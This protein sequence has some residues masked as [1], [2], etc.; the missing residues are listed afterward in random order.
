MFRKA[1][2]FLWSSFSGLIILCIVIFLLMGTVMNKKSNE[3]INEIGTLYM[4]EMAKQVQQKFD[5]VIDL[6]ILEVNGI[7][8]GNPP[9]DFY[10]GAEMIY[11]LSRSARVRN[12]VYLGLYTT[13]GECETIYG[14]PVE[15]YDEETFTKVLNDN[16]LRVF[17][18]YNQD[19]EKMLLLIIAAEY[20]MKN[21]KTSTAMVAGLPMEYLDNVLALSDDDAIVYSHIIRRDGTF[22][23]RTRDMDYFTRIGEMFTEVDGKTAEEYARE[24]QSA[25]NSDQDYSATIRADG[26]Y[27]HVLCTHLPDS[28]WYLVTVMPFGVLDETVNDLSNQHQYI[29]LGSC[30]IIL[31]AVLIIFALY[32]RMTRGQLRELE[33]AEQEA[34]RA[35]RAKS[36]FL[37]NMSHD[38]RT[39][40]NGI[41]GMT[42]IAMTNIQDTARVQDCLQKITLS[43]KHLLGLINDVLDMSKIESGKLSLNMD[44]LS[45]R[46][47][48]DSIVNIVQPQIKAKNQHFDIFISKIQTEDVYCDSVRLNQVL[49]NLLSNAIKF[50]PEGGTIN[51]Y[52]AQ[53][54]S[55]AGD[56]YVRC[57]FRV[58][59]TGIGMS[60]EF[61]QNIFETFTREKNEQVNKTEGTGLG[62]AITK[63][64]VDAMKGEIKVTS[65]PGKG[66]EFH[67]T[68]DLEKVAAKEEE[69]ILPPW[70][71][72]VVDNNK[73]LC[74]S[75]VDVLGE[76]GISA[77]WAL[78]GRTAVDMAEKHHGV[79]DDYQLVL[80]DWKM[81]DMDGLETTRELRK[82]LGE[83]V[84]I[85]IISAYDWSDI[86]KE[87][88]EAGAQGFISKPL[89]KSN[90]FMGLSR[91]V[92]EE[93]GVPE[94]KEEHIRDFAGKRI[95]LAEDNDLNWEIANEILTCAGF[96]LDR[97]EN[98]KIC[99]EKFEQSEPGTYDLILMDIRM[100]VMDGYEAAKAIRA[101]DR[102]DAG[103]PIIAMTADAFSEDI[104]RCLQCG[105]NAHIAKPIDVKKLIHELQK[106]M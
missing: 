90:L 11:Q 21:G 37:S 51:V 70:H 76:I 68:L 46:D 63:Y 25:I 61:Q 85:L 81:P 47:T 23:M 53:E 106:Y 77:D 34:V 66:S 40:M 104:Q 103:L 32:Y 75:A 100:P 102:R 19:E 97:A 99:V 35:N 41:V 74:S 87:A 38:I 98:G 57:H 24:L 52:L 59:D 67:V 26:T 30:S 101:L 96:E 105:M 13:D 88:L 3:A 9:E 45:L 89:F 18:G 50:T 39:P 12:F 15:P 28:E 48:M 14:D 6:Q 4:T 84:P 94:Q 91:F 62:M 10:Y 17:S 92:E 93:S 36:E 20:P 86:E 1:K 2:I 54:A 83:D 7:L 95:L 72:L 79:H 64:I 43:S 44:V 29:V 58:K 56:H 71:V 16:S 60:E 5:A 27:R 33:T 80:I 8:E 82:R 22:V 78:D 42:A 69:M 65:V 73:D 49:I 55:P 31:I